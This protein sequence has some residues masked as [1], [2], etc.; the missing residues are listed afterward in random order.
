VKSPTK[1][2]TDNR[3]RVFRGGSWDYATADI[4]RA[5]FR[6][7]NSPVYRDNDIGF[8]TVQSGARQPLKGA[9]PP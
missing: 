6:C 8:R 3:S 5:A 9:N 4:V 2:S 7:G 1:P